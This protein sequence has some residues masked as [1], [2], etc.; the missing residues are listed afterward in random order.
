[1]FP[2]NQNTETMFQRWPRLYNMLAA[3]L[4]SVR[5]LCNTSFE[6]SH[7]SSRG[8]A[9][10]GRTGVPEESPEEVTDESVAQL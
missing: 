7:E 5:V 8:L 4:G 9:L 10:C 2:E 6:S 1:M 3:K